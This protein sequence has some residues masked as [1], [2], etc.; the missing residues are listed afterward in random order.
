M[1]AAI[2]K[3]IAASLSALMCLS[4]AACGQIDMKKADLADFHNQL[5]YS[6]NKV[7]KH[8][9]IKEE[10]ISERTESDGGNQVNL[11]IKD[12]FNYNGTNATVRMVF[13]YDVLVSVEY[14]FTE[15]TEKSL[16]DAYSYIKNAEQAFEKTYKKP[17]N[18]EK[19][20][21]LSDLTEESFLNI[22][23]DSSWSNDYWI[24]DSRDGAKDKIA[25]SD[26]KSEFT[27]TLSLTKS[28]NTAIVKAL[29]WA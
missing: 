11:T 7:L 26:G 27:V 25:Q 18:Y 2:K 19:S 14:L 15:N 6:E 9:G 22:E 29:I 10:N 3:I 16:K 21:S 13:A 12:Q 28:G 17:D 4:L 23:K 20:P 1:K 5:G 24:T 8:I